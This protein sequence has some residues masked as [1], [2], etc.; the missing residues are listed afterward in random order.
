MKLINNY[1]EASLD[2]KFSDDE[3]RAFEKLFRGA[4]KHS[5]VNI[6]TKRI[7]KLKEWLLSLNSLRHKTGRFFTIRAISVKLCD[8]K[9]FQPIIDQSEIG[10]L[11]LLGTIRNNRIEF[12]VKLKIEPGNINYIQLSPTIQATKSN[13]EKVHKGKSVQFIELINNE[14]NKD[15]TL[16]DCLLSEQN[17]KFMKKKNRNIIKIVDPNSLKLDHN[18]VW[19]TIGQIKQLSQK[20]NIVNMDLRSIISGFSFLN[21]DFEECY[22]KGKKDYK[23]YNLYK[24]ELRNYNQDKINILVSKLYDYIKKKHINIEYV[25]FNQLANWSVFGGSIEHNEKKYFKVIGAKIDLTG[26]EVQCWE[27]PLIQSVKSEHNVLIYYKDSNSIQLLVQFKMEIGATLIAEIGPTIQTSNY[28]IKNQNENFLYDLYK[29]KKYDHKFS[30]KQSDEGGRFY[31]DVHQNTLIEV[32]ENQK[33]YI[34]SYVNSDR[35]HWIELGNIIELIKKGGP[36]NMQLR[37]ILSMITP[38]VI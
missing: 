29:L 9:W 37:G 10:V 18:S 32:S 14:K 3:Y 33:N 15:F 5:K 11:A 7:D 26:R 28:N 38:E 34:H 4:I 27:Q 6:E 31:H 17:S 12:L 20:D 35:Y 23:D 25:N 8:R 19:L 1:I 24:Y 22:S 13:Y 21:I 36:I 16:L 30:V 2:H